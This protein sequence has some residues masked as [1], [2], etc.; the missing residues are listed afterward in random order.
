MRGYKLKLEALKVAVN[1][2]SHWF[3]SGWNF[4]CC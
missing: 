2:V 3:F 4:N 1:S